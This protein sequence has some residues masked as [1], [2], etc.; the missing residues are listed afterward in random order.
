[1]PRRASFFVLCLALAGCGYPGDPLP[2]A[3]NI[4]VK[5]S[6]LHGGQHGSNI[7]LRFTPRFETT[8]GLILKTLGGIDLRGGPRPDGEFSHDAW[9]TGATKLPVVET[10]DESVTVEVPAGDWRGREIL[11]AVRTL[12]PTGRASDWSNIV[13]LRIVEPLARPTGLAASNDGKGIA[14][15]WDAGM[16][17]D[18]ATWRVYRATGAEAP[19]LLGRADAPKWLDQTTTYGTP[20][21]Y[22]V[23]RAAPGGDAEA[24]S[25]PSERVS[26]TPLDEF[27]PAPPSGL[28]VF[29]GVNTIELV[30]DRNIEA[31]FAF[32][33]VWRAVGD[34][35]MEPAGDKRTLPSFSDTALESGKRY[36]YA[37]T[38]IDTTGN[39]SKPCAPVEISAP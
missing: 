16:A 31:D 20:Y 5:V 36:R 30:W 22:F 13:H 10:S 23:Q 15:S 11:F 19:L 4:P 1:M 26:I 25:E 35:A 14:L 3:L 24:E 18:G 7:V 12:G 2:P 17:R 34:G 33:Q 28:R 8:D 27:P 37:V 6:D 21:S 9:A 38:S 39:E 32:Y 29:T